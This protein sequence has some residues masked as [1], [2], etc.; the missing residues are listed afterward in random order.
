MAGI[1]GPTRLTGFSGQLDTDGIIK[2]LMDTEKVPLNNLVKKKQMTL[3][4]REDYRSMNTSLLALRNTMNE[5]RF[6]SKFETVKSTSSNTAVLDISSSGTNPGVSNVKVTQLANSASII[7]EKVNK[8]P[9]EKLNLSGSFTIEGSDPAKSVEITV[10][11]DSTIDSIV[12]DINNASANTGV[13]ASFDRS[14]GILYLNSTATGAGSKVKVTDANGTFANV[15]GAGTPLNAQGQDSAYSVNGTNITANSNSVTING[16]QVT[17][18]GQ[19][20]ASIGAMADRSSVV[21]K[22]KNFVK[23]YNEIVDKFSEATTAKK[24]RAYQP[25]TSEEKEAMTDSQ[26]T[27]WEKKA[28]EGDLYNDGLLKDTLTSM[29]SALNIPLEGITDPSDPNSQLRLLSQIGINVINDFRENGKLEI[30][31]KKLQEAINTRFDEVKVLFTKSSDTPNDTPE[32]MKKRTSELGFADRLYETIGAQLTKFTKKIGSGS[33][34][35]LDE[36]VL[37]KQLKDFSKR[38]SDLERKLL[39]VENRYYKKFGA[40]EK[41]LQKLNSQGSW[42]SSQLR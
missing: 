2:K 32:N 16:V 11:A 10:T 41:A 20:E 8:L 36:S 13:K 7:S 1:S 33:I 34:E 25:L 3:W 37:G 40:M 12:K 26:I 28:R 15:F 29:R 38:E 27:L 31:E 9:T 21:D 14:S 22:L 6:E 18:R 39:D 4:Q 23:Q 24:N 30:D 42:I 35:A 19:G 5:L 17:L